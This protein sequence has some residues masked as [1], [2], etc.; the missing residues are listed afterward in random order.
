MSSE[1]DW[2]VCKIVEG[3][4]NGVIQIRERV[5]FLHATDA[6]QQIFTADRA[7]GRWSSGLFLCRAFRATRP[8]EVAVM[9]K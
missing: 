3:V 6:A 9:R 5:G 7:L 2:N 1:T 4:S 8:L